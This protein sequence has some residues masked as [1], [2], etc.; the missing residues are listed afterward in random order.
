MAYNEFLAD[1]MRFVLDRKNQVYIEKKMM[2]GLVFMV[3]NK[4]CLGVV[5]DDL[6]ARIDPTT[7]DEALKKKGSR[8]MDFTHRPMNGYIFVNLEGTDMDSD[9]EYWVDLALD[10]NPRA[11][12]SKK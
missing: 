5:K 12:A 10:F 1:R 11:K 4:M 7:Q 2:G 9:L 3:D 8:E 6:M